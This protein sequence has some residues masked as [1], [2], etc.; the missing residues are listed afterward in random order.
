M[1]SFWE[2][3]FPQFYFIYL[4]TSAKL[5]K[6]FKAQC[7]E[8]FWSWRRTVLLF[9]FPLKSSDF[10]M[11]QGYFCGASLCLDHCDSW[12]LIC[13]RRQQIAKYMSQLQKWYSLCHSVTGTTAEITKERA[14]ML[15]RLPLLLIS[16]NII[17]SR[18]LMLT[19]NCSINLMSTVS[20]FKAACLCNRKADSLNLHAVGVFL[21]LS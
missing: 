9:F 13:V 3:F 20:L 18:A 14:V 15:V 7:C 8:L 17:V 21:S 10:L 12:P 19:L 5:Q 1:F 16:A 11:Q 2:N 6:D 4:F